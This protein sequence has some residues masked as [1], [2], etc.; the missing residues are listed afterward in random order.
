[1]PYM[2]PQTFQENSYENLTKFKKCTL[3]NRC[4][5]YKVTPVLD[6]GIQSVL[7]VFHY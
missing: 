6:A 7:L 2:I 3:E 4:A 5:K 1:M